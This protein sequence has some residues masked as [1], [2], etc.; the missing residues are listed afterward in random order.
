MTP[1]KKPR[2]SVRQLAVALGYE[3]GVDA[4]PVVLAKGRGRVAEKILDAARESGIP[5]RSDRDLVECLA[6]ID[7]GGLIPPELYIVVAE[8]LAFIYRMNR[9]HGGLPEEAPRGR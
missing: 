1:E 5:V 4:A 9:E 3:P 8:V 2:P 6:R 7:L